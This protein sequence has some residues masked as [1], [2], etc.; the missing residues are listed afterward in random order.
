M[1]FTVWFRRKVEINTDPQ[2]R[3]YDGCYFS[4]KMEWTKW[5][6]ICSYSTENFAKDSAATFKRINP[7]QEY[8]V[9]PE[10]ESPN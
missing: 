9:K 6:S 5:S 10:G 7:S 8:I 4:S 2:K 3:C 1:K